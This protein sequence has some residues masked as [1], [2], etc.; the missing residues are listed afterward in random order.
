MN[1]NEQQ[2]SALSNDGDIFDDLDDISE[3]YSDKA[4]D[5]DIAED[6][7]PRYDGDIGFFEKIYNLF[8]R[9]RTVFNGI[10]AVFERDFNARR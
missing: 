2:N 3:E 1:K 9:F 6:F 10:H 5:R 8:V 4:E 7:L